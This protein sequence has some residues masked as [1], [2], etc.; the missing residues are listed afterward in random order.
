MPA[1][2]IGFRD[3]RG[4]TP[5]RGSLLID[6]FHGRTGHPFPEAGVC[7]RTMAMNMSRDREALR[8]AFL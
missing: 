1:A 4:Y 6:G 2:T 7:A 5:S 8:R 3:N